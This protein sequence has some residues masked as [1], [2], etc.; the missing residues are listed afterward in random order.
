M[1]KARGRQRCCLFRLKLQNTSPEFVQHR[2]LLGIDHDPAYAG[3]Y[4]NESAFSLVKYIKKKGYHTEVLMATSQNGDAMIPTSKSNLVLHTA[5]GPS[6]KQN[7]EA[8]VP[9]SSRHS[10][11]SS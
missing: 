9:S 11:V 7:E 5:L 2:I 6:K 8:A 10:Y 1:I 3:I 4:Q